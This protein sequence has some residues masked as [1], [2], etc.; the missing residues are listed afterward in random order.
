MPFLAPLLP[1]L[2]MG[3]ATTA[4][5]GA[6]ATALTAPAL[7]GSA[8]GLGAGLAGL[9]AAAPTLGPTL[10]AAAGLAAPTGI[11]AALTG[12]A[13]NLVGMG[14]NLMGGNLKGAGVNAANMIGGKSL[15][16]MVAN[17]SWANLGK[18][19][20]GMADK[21]ATNMVGNALMGNQQQPVSP[22]LVKPQ[23]ATPPPATITGDPILSKMYNNLN[24][25][26][27][28]S[29]MKPWPASPYPRKM[30]AI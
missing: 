15:G 8:G 6:A 11:G 2:G 7:M 10:G 14:K 17:P 4:G 1:A 18:V 9:G 30:S 13:P 25:Q 5:T 24:P 12:M 29:T 19:G 28:G 21:A 16:N 23:Q 26:F 27:Q 3:A 20:E 22:G